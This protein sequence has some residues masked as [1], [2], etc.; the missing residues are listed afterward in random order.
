MN[1]KESAKL[2][3][4]K[5]ASSRWHSIPIGA[6]AI[7][8]VA[9]LVIGGTAFAAYNLLTGSANVTV[10]EAITYSEYGDGDGTWASNEWT[11]DIY[12]A[13]TK[14]MVIAVSNAGSVAITVSGTIGSATGLT[15]SI[16]PLDG[17]TWLAPAGGSTYIKLSITADVS[18]TPVVVSLPITISR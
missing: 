10:K 12:P 17:Y 4:K 8:L 2:K 1:K 14:S 6:I 9:T 18:I 11:V 3:L 7:A 13:E 15:T 5:L 16:E